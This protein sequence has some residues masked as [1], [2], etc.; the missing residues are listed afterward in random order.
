M[1]PQWRGSA[2]SLCAVLVLLHLSACA[3]TSVVTRVGG[4]SRPGLEARFGKPVL[5]Q[6]GSARSVA[7]YRTAGGTGRGSHGV[8]FSGIRCRGTEACLVL[9]AGALVIYLITE[10]IRLY[11]EYRSRKRLIAIAYD[12]E[13]RPLC[14][15][16]GQGRESAEALAR[17]LAPDNAPCHAL[18]PAK[19][20]AASELCDAA[21]HGD[22]NARWRLATHFQAGEMAQQAYRWLRLAEL[23]GATPE[24]E[25]RAAI[26]SAL[27]PAARRDVETGLGIGPPGA[28]EADIAAAARAG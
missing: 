6:H 25:A 16:W 22:A 27:A 5:A 21:R 26:T 11:Q 8:P 12:D 24:P 20:F 3:G 23:A 18:D 19:S 17:R 4:M 14:L 10:P 1:K 28:C 2:R 13:D 7:V 15:A 9:A